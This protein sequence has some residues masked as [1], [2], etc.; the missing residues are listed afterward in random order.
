[1]IKKLQT[2]SKSV[3]LKVGEKNEGG[4]RGAKNY[5]GGKNAN[6]SLTLATIIIHTINCLVSC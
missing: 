3:I 1:M 5:E 4:D 2:L 6:R